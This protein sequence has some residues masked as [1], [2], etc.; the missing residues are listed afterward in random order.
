[1]F[2]SFFI[3]TAILSKYYKVEICI[4]YIE[5][6]QI[7]PINSS[8]YKQRIYIIYDNIHYDSLVFKGFGIKEKRIVDCT[9]EKAY[10]LA[11]DFL[12]ILLKH[13]LHIFF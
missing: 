3:E 1:M 10:Q 2:I 6:L 4:L 12:Q 7:I 11:F 9:D 5:E 8:N 13:N